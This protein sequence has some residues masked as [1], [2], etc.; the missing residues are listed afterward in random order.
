MPG[1]TATMWTASPALPTWP[2][3]MV[4]ARPAGGVW[5]SAHDLIRYVQLELALGKLPNGKRL[6]SEENLLMRRKPQIGIGEDQYYGM[7]LMVDKTWGVTVI[8]HG[9]SMAGFKT[10]LFFLP[11]DGI[12]AVLLH[13]SDNG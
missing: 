1:R 6:V 10:A 9:G 5:T 12:G 2:Y 13:T 11:D 7:G 8:H 3:S 4:P